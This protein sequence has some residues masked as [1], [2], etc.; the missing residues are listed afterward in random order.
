MGNMTKR[1]RANGT[2]GYTAQVRLKRDGKVYHTE[3]KTFDRKE[4][5][6]RITWADL[7]EAGS[8]I[9]V[10]DMKNPGQKIGDNVWCEPP[11]E[12][13]AIILAMRR[14]K[15]VAEIFPCSTDA[16]SAAFTRSGALLGI[17]DLRFHD[18]RHE[19]VSRLFEL[20]RSVPQAASVSGHR[21]WSSLQRYTHLRHVGDKFADWAWLTAI[22]AKPET[23]VGNDEKPR[24]P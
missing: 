18:L 2:F 24:Q 10:R 1:K 16:I 6:T 7:D 9:L 21:S 4:E 12:A 14:Q 5:I 17:T 19:G 15:G 23:G 8:R 3:A 11:P 13:L 22:T 20:G